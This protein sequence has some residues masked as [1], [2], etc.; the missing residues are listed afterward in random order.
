MKVYLKSCP[1]CSAVSASARAVDPKTNRKWVCVFIDANT[2]TNLVDIVVWLVNY[3]VRMLQIEAFP[4][5]KM[6]WP[7]ARPLVNFFPENTES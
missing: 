1:G 2:N 6:G 3:N 4:R 7:V 5:M